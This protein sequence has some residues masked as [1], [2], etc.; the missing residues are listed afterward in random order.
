MPQATGGRGLRKSR[1]LPGRRRAE[2]R[3]HANGCHHPECVPPLAGYRSPLRP[4]SPLKGRG[5]PHTSGMQGGTPE[6]RQETRNPSRSRFRSRTPPPAARRV[7][8]HDD[9]DRDH[10]GPND[11]PAQRASS[12]SDPRRRSKKAR[13]E[14]AHIPTIPTPAKRERHAALHTGPRRAAD[15]S[16][17]SSA[18]S[19]SGLAADPLPGGQ[20]ATDTRPR[21][22][23][24]DQRP[25]Q[26]VGGQPPQHPPRER[27]A[28]TPVPDTGTDHATNRARAPWGS[29]PQLQHGQTA[30]ARRAHRNNGSTTRAAQ[31]RTRK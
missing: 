11:H 15:G 25:V 10:G 3:Q 20:H 1:S 22:P 24:T 29:R 30:R 26:G 13:T 19:L 9:T 7:V 16:S 4:F 2:T 27:G 6:Q 5:S 28:M 18:A 31:R 14:Q 12:T 17:S 8:F 23:A 21:E